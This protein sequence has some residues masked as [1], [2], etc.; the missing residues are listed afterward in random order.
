M[1]RK[2]RKIVQPSARKPA[3]TF[4][5]VIATFSEI[6]ERCKEPLVVHAY[7]QKGHNGRKEKIYCHCENKGEAEGKSRCPK[8]NLE[9]CFIERFF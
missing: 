9:I 7:A 6:C 5:I 2:K 4:D 1:K 8:Y 3:R